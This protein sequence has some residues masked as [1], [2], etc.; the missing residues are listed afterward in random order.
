M[1]ENDLKEF[2]Q[3]TNRTHG[4]SP[5][6]AKFSFLAKSILRKT[7]FTVLELGISAFYRVQISKLN[8]FFEKL[9]GVKVHLCASADILMS[10][11]EKVHSSL[12]LFLNSGRIRYYSTMV[13]F[14]I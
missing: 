9:Q 14:N 6:F 5:L 10:K 1:T 12:Q 8:L 4:K 2:L 13:G 11:G 3:I 7:V